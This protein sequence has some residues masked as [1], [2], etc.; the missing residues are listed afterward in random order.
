MKHRDTIQARRVRL[1]LFYVVILAPA[2]FYGASQAMRSNANSP[3]DWVSGDFAPR[4]RYDAFTQRFGPGDTVIASWEGCTIDEPALDELV[5][6]LRES[7]AFYEGDRWYFHRVTSGREIALMIAANS[8]SLTRDELTGRLSGS[9]IGP[10]GATTYVAITFTPEALPQRREIVEQIQTCITRVCGAPA[11]DQH[12]AGPVIDGLSVDKAGQAS[13]ARLAIPSALAVLF[14][15]CICLRSIRVG[16]IVFG[17]SFFCQASTLAIIHYSGETMSALL[18]V[19]PPLIQ[20]LAVAGG[21]HLTNYYFES[22]RSNDDPSTAPWLAVK[23]GWLPCLLSAGTT[24]LGVGSLLVSRL[25]PIRLFGAYGA[26]GVVITAGLLLT[27]V[28]ALLVIWPQ[29]HGHRGAPLRQR[30]RRPTVKLPLW[31]ALTQF[32]TR[33]AQRHRRCESDSNGGW[34]LRRWLSKNVC[35]HRHVIRVGSPRL[36][37]LRL[38]GSARGSTGADRN[39]GDLSCQ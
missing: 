7:A 29:R 12:L 11:M 28:P 6:E 21:V 30:G 16:L 19:L 18:I 10:D 23:M 25:T 34:R 22:L 37:R 2:I 31:E 9:T 13:L 26:A 1:L 35:S 3:I 4:V 8:S 32:E 33:S 20:V 39:R 36:E 14:L 27:L 17:F 38:A 5:R 15:A 24:A